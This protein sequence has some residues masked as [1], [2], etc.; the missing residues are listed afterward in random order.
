MNETGPGRA[1]SRP[2]AAISAPASSTS[3]RTTSSR[4]MASVPY[5]EERP[6]RAA[7]GLRSHEAGRRGGR[8]RAA[9]RRRAGGP[10]QLGLRGA[11]ATS[12]PPC[13][14]RRP[15]GAS[16][17]RGGARCGWSTTSVGRPT[18]A[19][20][21]AEGIWRLVEAGASGLYHLSNA[22]AGLLVGPRA[23]LPRRDR[24][25][26]TSKWSAFATNDLDLRGRPSR[27]GPSWTA[28]RRPATGR[29]RCAPGSDAVRAYL[30]V[31][32]FPCLTDS[33]P[34]NWKPEDHREPERSPCRS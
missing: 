15:S 30:D 25:P 4:A 23:L 11:A 29:R 5:R 33:S 9:L 13:S 20:D 8:L 26:P 1:G 14:T 10:H 31:S 18:Y 7:L 21:L 3:P 6:H 27:P 34:E 17:D 28:R 2:A 22:G 32:R 12:S 19:V 24:P 16:G